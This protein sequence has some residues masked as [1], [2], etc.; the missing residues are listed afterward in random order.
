MTDSV[1]PMI[2]FSGIS[3]QY[4]RVQ[5][6]DQLSFDILPGEILCLLGPSGCGKSTC[7]TL[8]AGFELPSTGQVLVRGTPVTGP[9]HDRSV[10]FQ[11]PALM[12]W[13]TVWN[14]VVLGPRCRGERDYEG[15][16]TEMLSTVRLSEFRDHYPYQL[17]GGMMQRA[18]I[19]RAL[20]NNAEILLMD[21]PFG[22][23]DAQTRLAMQ[24]MLLDIQERYR[25][26]ILFITHDVDEAIFLGDRVLIMSGRPGR[27]VETIEVSFNRPRSYGLLTTPGFAELKHHVLDLVHQPVV[28]QQGRAACKP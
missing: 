12:P 4:G 22:A 14:N 1:K 15:R 23:L 19:A 28:A 3:K 13:K 18:A 11:S 16:A 9:G 17:S 20:L 6:L 25:S 7:L 24:E 10:V 26:T 27:I 5:A 8:A 21:E 2:A